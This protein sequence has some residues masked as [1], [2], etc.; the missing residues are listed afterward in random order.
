MLVMP[1]CLDMLFLQ[2]FRSH[3]WQ[4]SYY[5]AQWRSSLHVE[6]TMDKIPDVQDAS[7]SIKYNL[8]NKWRKGDSESVTQEP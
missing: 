7:L 1:I 8:Q 3:T 5:L 6:T 2:A 4:L